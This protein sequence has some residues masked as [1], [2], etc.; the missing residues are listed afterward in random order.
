MNWKGLR[1]IVCFCSGSWMLAKL[2]RSERDFPETRKKKKLKIEL[3]T[4]K[5]TNE[6]T[7]GKP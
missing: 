2:W 5:Q 3:G 7:F 4:N 6:T 1:D